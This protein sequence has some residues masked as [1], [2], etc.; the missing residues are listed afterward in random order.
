MVHHSAS[1]PADIQLTTLKYKNIPPE[2][3][4][5]ALYIQY[6]MQNTTHKS[7]SFP[8]DITKNIA[9]RTFL[10]TGVNESNPP[11]YRSVHL[12]SWKLEESEVTSFNVLLILDPISR[13]YFLPFTQNKLCMKYSVTNS[14]VG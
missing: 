1:F 13:I 8:S 2:K 5:S 9:I 14:M 12:I 11:F 6:V 4:S 7:D 10:Q 3:L